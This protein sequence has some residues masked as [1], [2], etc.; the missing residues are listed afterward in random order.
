[1]QKLLLLCCTILLASTVGLAQSDVS[2]IAAPSPSA[3][4]SASPQAPSGTGPATWELGLGYQFAQL[5]MPEQ[6]TVNAAVPA[7][8]ANDSGADVSLTRF[9]SNLIGLEADVNA[10]FGGSSTPLITTSQVLFVGGGARFA[11]RGHG[12]VE[13]WA[14]AL[15]GF[16]HFSFTQTATAYGSNNSFA[17]IVGG[18]ADFTMT[19]R[20]GIR[21]NADFVGSALFSAV[22]PNWRAGAGV[23]FKF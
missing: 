9:L 5:R 21:V 14:H 16:D 12:R 19:P 11:W 22:Q 7:F 1:M 6:H 15:A 4:P 8:T 13:P 18:G 23:V 3:A 17:F 10:S 20:I 2:T